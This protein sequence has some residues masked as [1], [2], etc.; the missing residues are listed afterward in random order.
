MKIKKADIILAIVIAIVGIAA[1]LYLTFSDVPVKNGKV[2][3][4][5]N[6]KV[7]GEYSLYEDRVI[8]VKDD[9]HINKITIK[10]GNVQMTFSNCK[11]QDCVKQ[12]TIDDSSKSIVCLP[13]KVVVEIK[14]DE[15]EFDSVSR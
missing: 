11:N 10:N 12:G 15:S 14:S 1:S 13:H 8:T 9:D 2:V 3:I 7:Y 6:N 5:Q 4:H